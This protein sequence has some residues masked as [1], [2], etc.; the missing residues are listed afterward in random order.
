VAPLLQE[1]IARQGHDKLHLRLAELVFIGAGGI[2]ALADPAAH[3]G[4]HR[5]LPQALPLLARIRKRSPE[6]AG[7]EVVRS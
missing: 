1:G 2:R 7:S 4:S 6:P 3:L 5:L